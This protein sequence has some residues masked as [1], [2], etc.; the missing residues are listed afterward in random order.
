MIPPI[1]TNWQARAIAAEE[2]VKQVGAL[3]DIAREELQ[4]IQLR[5]ADRAALMSMVQDGRKVKLVFVRNGELTQIEVYRTMG[6]D[7]NAIEQRLLR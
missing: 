7:W 2:A 5:L 3:L 1:R 6:D 4:G